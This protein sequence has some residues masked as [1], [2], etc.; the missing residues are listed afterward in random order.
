MTTLITK[1]EAVIL[2][3]DKLNALCEEWLTKKVFI[4][5]NPAKKRT[6]KD[7]FAFNQF[8]ELYEAKELKK[9]IKFKARL[10]EVGEAAYYE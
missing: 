5:D 7:E 2:S 4:L 8:N 10:E 3:D 1:E 9:E 6:E